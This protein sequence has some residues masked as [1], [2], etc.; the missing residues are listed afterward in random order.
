MFYR[1]G[2]V[3]LR[4]ESQYGPVKEAEYDTTAWVEAMIQFDDWK[5]V[6]TTTK[7]MKSHVFGDMYFVSSIW[8]RNNM[9]YSGIHKLD[10]SSNIIQRTGVN[11]DNYEWNNVMRKADDINMALFGPQA[12]KGV[13]QSA[14][15]NELQMWSYIW[16]VNGKK[17]EAK[18]QLEFFSEEDAH[19]NAELH[20]PVTKKNDK[21]ELEVSS[22]YKKHP[23][24]TMQM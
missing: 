18:P 7:P 11:L 16:S 23:Q 3:I 9:R 21:A 6:F 2:K 13:K 8:E 5:E 19:K 1:E 17:I 14:P 4:K 24:E 20:K 12:E 15:E 22:E 10:A